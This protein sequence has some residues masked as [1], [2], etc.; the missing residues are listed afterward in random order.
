MIYIEIHNSLSSFAATQLREKIFGLFRETSHYDN[1]VIS[2]CS[3]TTVNRHTQSQPF[4]RLLCTPQRR[5]PE[6][7]RSLSTLGY[8]IQ[9]IELKEFLPKI[10]KQATTKPKQEAAA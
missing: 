7:L 5:I 10:G 3:T 1:I 8:D 4:I 2:I 6:I 9:F